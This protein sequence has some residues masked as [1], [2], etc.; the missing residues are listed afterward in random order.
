MSNILYPL[1]FTPAYKTKIWGG[2]KFETI[3]NRHGIPL[4]CGESWEVSG[5]EGDLSEVSNGFL[6]GN[7][8]D[9]LIEVYMGD[10]VGDSV[11]ETFGNSFPLLVKFIDATDD[12]SVQVHPGDDLASERHGSWG[13]TEMWYVIHAEDN[14]NLVAGFNRKISKEE[15]MTAVDNG[16]LHDMLN[17]LK[18]ENDDAFF[19]PPGCVHAIG[20]GVLLVEVQQASDVTYRIY[21]YNRRDDDGNLRELQTDLALDAMDFECINNTKLKYQAKNNE[22]TNIIDCK[23]FT[24]NIFK[25]DM[26]VER[27]FPEID[28]FIIYIC[29]EGGCNIEYDDN[30]DSIH[31]ACGE[32]VLV[33]AAIKNLRFFPEGN[34]KLLEVYIKTENNH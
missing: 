1:K 15:Y 6:K 25:L 30:D 24:T 22:S 31:I 19:V 4:H 14:S 23:Y 12:L 18:V 26:P 2:N 7:N 29:V 16:S 11:Y 5:V 8:L 33:P 13:K 9:E 3:F 21:D 10:L 34:T 27:D 20:K 17:F 32:T 28:S